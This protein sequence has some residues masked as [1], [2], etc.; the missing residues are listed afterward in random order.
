MAFNGTLQSGTPVFSTGKFG[1][2]LSGAVYALPAIT[3]AIAAGTL[4]G[5]V[6]ITSSSG[7]FVAFGDSTFHY[8]WIGAVGGK[9]AMQGPGSSNNTTST[10]TIGD[11]VWHHVAMTSD[12]TNTNLYVDG[13]LASTVASGQFALSSAFALGALGTAGFTWPGAIDEIRVSNVLR[14][15]GSSYTVPTAAF[16]D[17]SSTLALYHL[18]SDATDSHGAGGGLALSNTVAPAV[19]P[20][21]SIVTGTVLTTTNGTWSATPD[22]YTYQ[23]NRAGS[24]ISGATSSTYTVVSA[25][26]GLALTA[27]VTAVKATYTSASATSNAVTPATTAGTIAANDANIAYS[28]YTWDV[29]SVR[30]KTINSGAYL[31]CLLTGT[32]TSVVANFD[33]SGISSPA[34]QISYRVDAGPW[35]PAT[36]AATVSIPIPSTNTGTKHLVE[37]QVKSTPE[38]ANRWNPQSTAVIFTGLTVSPNTV[39]TGTVRKKRFN[40]LC[41]GDSITEGVRTLGSSQTLETDRNDSS[42]AWAY[43]LGAFLGAEVGVVGFGATGLNQGGSGGVPAFPTSY[44]LLWSGTSR[45]FTPAPDLILINEGTNDG[46]DI[47]TNA[48]AVLNGLLAATPSSTKIAIVQQWNGTGHKAQWQAAITA[49][50]AASRVTYVDTTGW[51]SGSDASDGLHP[52][53]YVN[54]ADLAPRLA[55]AVGPLL[56]GASVTPKRFVNVGG[57]A[58]AIS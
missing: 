41:Y 47:T 1:N 7:T 28:P 57:T 15:T 13:A 4:E 31:S 20:T 19:T 14:Y 17:D 39:T 8:P 9:A 29:T 21:S 34:P 2:G 5:W 10:V 49:S 33:V 3:T 54:V 55:A 56:T 25:D 6:K 36:L 50:T 26:A 23:W 44:N 24:A 27:V 35:T 38:A 22:S 42:V 45:V 46:G 52:Y 18:E 43:P 11:G 40:I 51:W 12:G 37:I 32:A 58:K 16:T 48:T 53:G 30:A